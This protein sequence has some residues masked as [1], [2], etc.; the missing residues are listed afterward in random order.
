METILFTATKH[1]PVSH[2]RR[3]QILAEK[4]LAKFN[5]ANMSLFGVET[6]AEVWSRIDK[7]LQ[8]S[9]ATG[10]EITNWH[11]MLYQRL[12]S[13]LEFPLHGLALQIIHDS[14]KREKGDKD[15]WTCLQVLIWNAA[16]HT[17][18]LLNNEKVRAEA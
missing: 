17:E 3:A 13:K 8:E 9:G 11:K 7:Q 14:K 1:D 12:L 16:G 15:Y 4:G 10:E 6:P 2:N 18:A 5:R